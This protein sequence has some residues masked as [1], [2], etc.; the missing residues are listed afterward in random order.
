MSKKQ[1][2]IVANYQYLDEF[3]TAIETVRERDDFTGFEAFSPTSYH[4][5]EHASG[6]KPS[7]VR[8][9]TLI[10]GLTGTCI[11]FALALAMDW[12]WPIVVGGKTAGIPS[13]PAYVVI[14]FETT[15]LFG[16]F[17]TIFGMLFFGR[18]GNPQAHIVEERATDDRFTI[19][20]PGVTAGSEQA[21]LLKSLGAEEIKS[22]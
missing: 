3:C 22:V 1:T 21:T 16:A 12:D 11:G 15:I 10:A 9:F 6:F 5:I 8:F 2:G 4:E 14:G 18:L 20:V 17:G 19:F 7:P 13:L